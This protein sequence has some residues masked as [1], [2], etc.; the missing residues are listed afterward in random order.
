MPSNKTDQEQHMPNLEY[1][2]ALIVGGTSGIGKGTAT[3]LA[4]QGASVILIGRSKSKGL[5]AQREIREAAGHDRVELVPMDLSALKQTR[6]IGAALTDHLGGL[7]WVLQTAGGINRENVRTAEG[8]SQ[9]LAAGYLHRPIINQIVQ[10]CL[11]RS[12]DPRIVV[13]T[14]AVPDTILPDWDNLEGPKTTADSNNSRTSR[15]PTSSWFKISP[16]SQTGPPSNAVGLIPQENKP[17]S[18]LTA[19]TNKQHT[20]YKEQRR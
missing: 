8:N 20:I 13:T 2:I 12:C 19:D 9:M 18:P 14:A 6:N 3:L 1:R 15:Q 10:P 7:D 4:E 11:Q 17:P 5:A 16:R